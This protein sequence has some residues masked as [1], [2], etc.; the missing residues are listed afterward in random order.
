M[1]PRYATFIYI[2]V[3]LIIAKDIM[4]FALKASEHTHSHKVKTV[5]SRH[6]NIKLNA[7][8]YH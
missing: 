1:L 8:G 7:E 6:E 5:T 4:F 2:L 3:C